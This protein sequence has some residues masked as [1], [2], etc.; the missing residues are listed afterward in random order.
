[1]FGVL[2]ASLA[3]LISAAPITTGQEG[4]KKVK[5][6]AIDEATYS[7][8]V[9]F[10]QYDRSLPL[11][12]EV[13]EVREEESYSLEKVIFRSTHDQ[14][15]PALL[16]LPKE[17]GKP[18]P[19]VLIL[20]S[21]SGRKENMRGWME[22]MASAGYA[23]MA[24]DAQYHGERTYV[25]GYVH[26]K[27][28]MGKG[29]WYRIRDA[30]IQTAIDHRRAI[31]YLETREEIDPGRIAALGESMGGLI[32]VPLSAVDGR[33]KVCVLV[34][35]GAIKREDEYMVR[36]LAPVSPVNFVSHISPR[37]F[38]MQSGRLDKVITPEQSQALYEAAGEPKHID[39]YDI[40][41]G[42]E[43]GDYI[44]LTKENILRWLKRYL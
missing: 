21:L 16:A 13:I 6:E 42:P 23:S 15:V 39:W 12:A 24:L 2:A 19:C 14:T 38:L 35:S 26:P 41:H 3:A 32:A 20:H 17:G 27:V 10:Y 5:S 1:M 43:A 28:M 37:S 7:A 33:I 18:F 40:G 44:G 31:D 11:D 8:Y 36:A 34:L 25:G 30:F 29:Q 9:E 22:V 4:G